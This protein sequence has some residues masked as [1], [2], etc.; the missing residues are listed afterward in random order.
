MDVDIPQATKWNLSVEVLKGTPLIEIPSSR[1]RVFRKRLKI[2]FQSKSDVISSS[3]L[4]LKKR[5]KEKAGY[6][7]LEG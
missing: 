5:N 2:C 1:K 4:V 7:L 3:L 6:S